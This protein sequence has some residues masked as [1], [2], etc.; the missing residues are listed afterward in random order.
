[1]RSPRSLVAC[2]LLLALATL[3]A[4]GGGGSSSNATASQGGSSTSGEQSSEATSSASASQSTGGGD[5]G[6]LVD[7]LKPP[8]STQISR[9]D[10]SGGVFV[11]W[12]STDSADSLKGFYESAIPKT[13]MKIISTTSA[14]GAFSWIFAETEGSSHGGSVTVGPSSDGGSGSTVV[15]TAT[16][17]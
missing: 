12:Q 6:S 3:A 16:T 4:C 1:M 5:L 17:G 9:T 14:S 7:A 15:L 8:N 11:S 13:G 2:A 10:A